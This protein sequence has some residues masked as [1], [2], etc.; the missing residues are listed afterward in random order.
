MWEQEHKRKMRCTNDMRREIE[1]LKNKV[2]DQESEEYH[3]QRRQRMERE[4]RLKM[5][6]EVRERIKFEERERRRMEEEVR[7]KITFEERERR[8]INHCHHR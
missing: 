2:N 6:E 1:L 8:R 5:E 4:R 7:E 3:L